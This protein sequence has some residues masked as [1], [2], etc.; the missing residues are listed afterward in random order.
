MHWREQGTQLSCTQTSSIKGSVR[1]SRRGHSGKLHRHNPLTIAHVRGREGEL[2]SNRPE[3]QEIAVFCLHLI[4]VSLALIT[5]LLLQV[6][7]TEET[8]KAPMRPEDWRG[9]TP[10]SIQHVNPYGRFTLDLTRCLP[11]SL[12][13]IA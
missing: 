11:L 5:T 13:N 4:Q 2:L 3:D 1:I 9:L 12:T 8:W 7:L 6:I 10:S